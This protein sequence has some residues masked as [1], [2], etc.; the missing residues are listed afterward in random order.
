MLNLHQLRV[1]VVVVEQRG[2][3]RA[4]EHLHLT[5]PAVSAQIR[6][7]RAFIGGPILVRDG[8]GVAPTE[9]GLALYRYAVE[10]LRETDA[11]QRNLREINSG[12]LDHIVIGGTRSY[13]GYVLPSILARFQQSHP[14]LRFS[15]VDATSVE[16]VQRVHAGAVDVAVV[17]PEQVPSELRA[18]LGTTHLCD[19][20][21]IIVESPEHPFSRNQTMT[22]EEIGNTPF[23]QPM[24]PG[25]SSATALGALFSSS[26]L[27]RPRVTM[28]LDTWE[29]VKDAVRTG[30][31]M[32]RIPESAARRELTTGELRIVRI[33][34]HREVRGVVLITSPHRRRGHP[35][36]VSSSS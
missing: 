34:G 30:A 18:D 4:A 21:I 17:R 8:R 9:A 35:S 27:G 24:L 20:E 28:D 19:D 13:S 2:L 23:V 1:F 33:E 11:L 22:L 26:G 5:E 29:G 31:G 15:V 12:E 7:L 3:T 14:A 10:V 32:A 25:D 36:F 6:H 16:L